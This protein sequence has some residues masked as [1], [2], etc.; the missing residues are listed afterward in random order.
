MKSK[1]IIIWGVALSVLT[2]I[3]TLL[4]SC[5]SHTYDE[6]AGVVANPVYA[7]NIRPIVQNNCISC[8]SQENGQTPYFETYDQFKEQT[9][10]GN[11]ICRIDD[12]SCG[13]VMPQAGRM[14]QVN[15]DLIKTWAANGCPEQ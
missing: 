5:D 2:A 1:N 15:I 4:A 7:T 9:L 10:N 6:A 13:S 3:T 8:H 14:P 11:V 12:Q